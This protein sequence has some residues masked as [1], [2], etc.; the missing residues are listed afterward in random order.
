MFYENAICL[1]SK[2]ALPSK[3]GHTLEFKVYSLEYSTV[4]SVQG[5][6]AI[7]TTDTIKF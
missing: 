4:F 5:L 6:N 1:L 2:K 3:S 7:D